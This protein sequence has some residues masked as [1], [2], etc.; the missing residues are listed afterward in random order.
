MM[1]A[2]S[3]VVALDILMFDLCL[4][5]LQQGLSVFVHT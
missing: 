1:V 5:Q 3:I 4:I 2:P